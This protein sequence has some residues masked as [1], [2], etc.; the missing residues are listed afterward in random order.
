MEMSERGRARNDR[1]CGLGGLFGCVM[2]M[3]YSHEPLF[4]RP[5][6][7]L[8]MAPS[9]P[10][11]SQNAC[12]QGVVHMAFAAVPSPESSSRPPPTF[13]ISPLQKR[14]VHLASSPWASMAM[15]TLHHSSS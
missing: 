13:R 5:A 14:Q 12:F 7:N 6:Y 9:D 15:L 11:D 2:M 8:E 1:D 10:Q 4:G 3:R